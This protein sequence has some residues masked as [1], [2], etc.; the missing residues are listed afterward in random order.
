M[1]DTT[2]VRRSSV[3]L[4][5]AVEGEVVMFHPHRGAY[6]SLGD[7]GSRI[8]EIVA[9]PSSLAAITTTLLQEFK[10]EPGVCRAQVEAFV[11]ELEDAGIVELD[12]GAGSALESARTSRK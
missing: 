4:T 5:A 3:P 2:V 1:N 12:H 9:A 8:W 11:V 6:F 10:V 7:V